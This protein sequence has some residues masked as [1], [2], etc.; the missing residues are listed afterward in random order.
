[1]KNLILSIVLI[2]GPHVTKHKRLP[3][4]FLPKFRFQNQFDSV[5]EWSSNYHMMTY[6]LVLLEHLKLIVYSERGCL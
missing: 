3:R 6:Q 2:L 5:V 4:L 1:M